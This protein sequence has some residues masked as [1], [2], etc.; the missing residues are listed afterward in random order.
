MSMRVGQLLEVSYLELEVYAGADGLE[1]EIAWTQVSELPDPTEW[2]A[3]GGLVMT[4]GLGLPHEPGAQ[5][6]YIERL[7]AAGM[8]GLMIGEH[9]WEQVNAPAFSTEFAAAADER[10]FPILTMPYDHPFSGVA[11]VVAQATHSEEHARLVQTLQIYDSVRL[12]TGSV[13]GPE[14]V[15]RLARVVGCEL[16]VLDP[17]NGSPLFEGSSPLEPN[18]VEEVMQ[19]FSRGSVAASA[20]RRLTGAPRP[21]A[22]LRLPASVEAVL[23]ASASAGG[24]SEPDLFVLRHVAAVVA[25][26]VEKG[27]AE[28]E[29]RRRLGAD[30][31]TDLLDNRIEGQSAARMLEQWDLREGSLVLAAA[32][33]DEL[34]SLSAN[35]NFT[36][37]R[38]TPERG[39]GELADLQQRLGRR[40]IEFIVTRKADCLVIL[41]DS[42]DDTLEVLRE[43]LGC[44]VGVSDPLA[45]L[46][47]SGDAARE[48]RWAL[49]EARATGKEIVRYGQN[50]NSHF[51]PRTLSESRAAIR[52]V[53]GPIIDY[54]RENGSHLVTSLRTY[55]SNNRS[56]EKAASELYVHKQ[57]VVYRMHRVEQLTG[58]RLDSMEEMA[59]FWLALR[60]MR[61]M[62][63]HSAL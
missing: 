19:R 35:G 55:L 3:A 57:T 38:S 59:N 44:A 8:S 16:H 25:W 60:A 15:A 31:L 6:A 4:T 20:L 63:D 11:Q 39:E 13:A 61:E 23:V 27:Q 14:L 17:L 50:T 43:E 28:Q 2:L 47:R 49:Q 34:G 41:L 52:H 32:P 46:A 45:R 9:P 48:A 12:A 62:D 5:R 30:L 58:R 53:L 33:Y 24:S 37:D 40:G 21:S 36:S 56:L 29:R 10:G 7:D 42:S 1:R 22:A 18:I 51:L 54:D 26:E